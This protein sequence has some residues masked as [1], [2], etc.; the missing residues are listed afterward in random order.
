MRFADEA[1]RLRAS[2]QRSR[3]EPD[4]SQSVVVGPGPLA[5]D[6]LIDVA[7]YGG[8]SRQNIPTSESL[9]HEGAMRKRRSKGLRAHLRQ[10]P[11]RV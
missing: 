5:I 1:G 11:E 4:L 2:W 9:R 10:P 8:R 6:T 7:G 3:L